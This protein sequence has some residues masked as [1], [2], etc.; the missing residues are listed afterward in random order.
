MQIFQSEEDGESGKFRSGAMWI[1]EAHD[2]VDSDNDEFIFC[3]RII[4]G[5]WVDETARKTAVR[6]DASAET[7]SD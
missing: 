1:D 2:S 5:K 4:A 3:G 7:E 6:T